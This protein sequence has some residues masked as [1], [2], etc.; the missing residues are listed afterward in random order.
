MADEDF[1]VL[2]FLMSLVHRNVMRAVGG[3]TAWTHI[4]PLALVTP[5]STFNPHLPDS[6][7]AAWHLHGNKSFPGHVIGS[8]RIYGDEWAGAESPPHFVT[9]KLHTFTHSAPVGGKLRSTGQHGHLWLQ[10]YRPQVVSHGVGFTL[11]RW[12]FCWCVLA[13]W[14]G[15]TTG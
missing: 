1:R 2:W 5:L 13:T 8:W 3:D 14:V 15:V 12:C 9:Y 10:A 6:V 7:M 11:T 4:N